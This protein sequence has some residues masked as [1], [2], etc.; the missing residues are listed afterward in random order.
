MTKILEYFQMYFSI[1]NISILLHSFI[2]GNSL[3]SKKLIRDILQKVK[4]L[5]EETSIDIMK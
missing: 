5:L 1:I 4:N 3:F 2:A